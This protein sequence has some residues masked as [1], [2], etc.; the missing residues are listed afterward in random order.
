MIEIG[1]FVHAVEDDT[2]V[3]EGVTLG[4]VWQEHVVKGN[5]GNGRLHRHGT[6]FIAKLEVGEQ[7][8]LMLTVQL[9][10]VIDPHIAAELLHNSGTRIVIAEEDVRCE[11][12]IVKARH[13]L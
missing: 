4:V 8:D 3:A 6:V 11:F 2:A 10:T 1:G 13:H 5:I 9:D 12:L 7:T